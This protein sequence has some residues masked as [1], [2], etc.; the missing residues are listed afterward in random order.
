MGFCGEFKTQIMGTKIAQ[1]NILRRNTKFRQR[2][3]KYEGYMRQET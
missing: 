3:S 2:F 1:K